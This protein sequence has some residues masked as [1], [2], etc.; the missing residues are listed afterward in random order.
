MGLLLA[1]GVGFEPTVR[2]TV[3]L[4]SS[5]AHSTTLAPLRGAVLYM[6]KGPAWVPL[7]IP[8]YSGM[9]IERSTILFGYPF[10][11]DSTD[12]N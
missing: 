6:K 12:Y 8:G 1:E 4:I 10:I 11:D 7:G 9:N 2:Q 5:Q 3:H